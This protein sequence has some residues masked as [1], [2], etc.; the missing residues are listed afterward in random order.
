MSQSDRKI[1][2]RFL[3]SF[4]PEQ[5]GQVERFLNFYSTTHRFNKR[6]NACVRGVASHFH[7]ALT[8]QSLANRLR[9]SLA[10]DNE[11]L[12]A[13]GYSPAPHA[14][15][16]AAV[17]ETILCELYASIDCTATLLSAIYGKLPGV[18]SKSTRNLF[19]NAAKGKIDGR[20]PKPLLDAIVKAEPWVVGLRD[21]RDTIS[22]SDTGFC[23]LDSET[24]IVGYMNP[25]MGPSDRAH[26]I[27]DI[28]AEVEEYF[29]SVNKWLGATFLFLNSEL[30]DIE[31]QQFCGFFSGRMYT[32]LVRPSEATSFHGGRCQ[33]YLWFE[34]EG[35]PTC[36]RV[37]E[38]GAYKRK[39]SPDEAP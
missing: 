8:L 15:E 23:H 29:S 13:E 16:L 22:H 25:A 26:V 1:S 37:E 35:N 24:G 32:R 4:A 38:C 11:Q 33:A 9:P 20:F 17:I 2:E 19:T 5:W 36:P 39:I 21:I 31:T 18:P 27:D 10:R 12:E 14:R 3:R 30:K 28:F 6:T 34:K 7:K